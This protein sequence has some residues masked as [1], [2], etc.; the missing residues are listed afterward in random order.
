MPGNYSRVKKYRFLKKKIQP[1]INWYDTEHSID[2]KSKVDGENEN[3]S[4]L[5]S[6]NIVDKGQVS[7]EWN[8]THSNSSADDFDVNTNLSYAQ[9]IDDNLSANNTSFPGIN[10]TGSSLNESSEISGLEKKLRQWALQNLNTLCLNVVTA[11]LSALRSEGFTDLPKT[12]Q[13]LLGTNHCRML[14]QMKGGKNTVG[15]FIYLGIEAGLKKI[16]SNKYKEEEI[17]VFVHI[18]G[19]QIFQNSTMQVWP[20]AIKMFHE[21]YVTKPFVTAI[22]CGEGKPHSAS[23]FLENFITEANNLINNGLILHMRNYK[24]KILGI[25]ADTPARAFLKCC[26][27]SGGFFACERCTTQGV[28]VSTNKRRQKGEK[29]TSKRV[30]PE[31]NCKKRT[32]KSFEKKKQPGHHQPNLDCPL[33]S[34]VNFNPVKDVLLDSMHLLYSGVMKNLLADKWISRS[35]AT[36]LKIV[37]T[38]RIKNR[39]DLLTTD[40]PCEFQRKKFDLNLVT[41][42][43]ATQYRFFLHYC[44]PFILIVHCD[45]SA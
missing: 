45:T 21:K 5:Q 15:Q 23:E 26:K 39:L 14:Q 34:L 40:V 25:I 20:V 33:L 24:F 6:D 3:V 16:I 29:H 17:A 30:Y 38:H 2:V 4:V 27:N 9:D 42:W 41:Q 32:K 28:S 12:A 19:M 13:T 36:R 18:D 44:G 35:S 22:F 31:I 37:D 43:K 10:S 11:L 7:A 8:V 1:N